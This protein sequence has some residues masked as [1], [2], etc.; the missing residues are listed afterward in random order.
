MNLS[1]L[2]TTLATTIPSVVIFIELFI[3]LPVLDSVY[4]IR[5]NA[6]KALRLFSSRRISEHWKEKAVLRYARLIL[7]ASLQN[8]ICLIILVLSFSL[9]FCLAGY[10]L[11]DN[12]K[13]VLAQ[14]F[15]LKTQIVAIG[16]GVIYAFFRKK[17]K[18]RKSVNDYSMLSK[19]LHHLALDSSVIKKV[20]FDVDCQVSRFRQGSGKSIKP[21]FVT[22]LARAGTTIL[23]EALYSTGLFATLT[24]RDMPFV[25]APL[26]WK[27]LTS[28]N[29]KESDLKERAHGDRLK[30]N[31]DSPEAFE[32]VFWMT[33]TNGDYIKES[34]LEQHDIDEEVTENYRKFVNNVIAG[35][36]KQFQ[37]L[38][39]AKNN[40]N[41]LRISA[42]KEA[43]PDG[44]IVV[45][46]RN[47]LDHAKSLHNQHKRFSQIHSE[48]AFSLRYMNWLGHYEF[49]ENFKP[50]KFSDEVIPKYEGEPEELDYWLRY[51][52]C[53][54]EYVIDCHISD[55]ILFDYDM[56][57]VDPENGL[58][59]L[60]RTL[61][62]D[63]ALM[64]RFQ[65]KV[66]GA[67][68]YEHIDVER[69]IL[70][71]AEKVHARLLELSL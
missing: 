12:L 19:T 2:F 63:E 5:D 6:F 25:T 58:K 30:V 40:N 68:K 28:G 44:A 45:P 39:L 1:E 71:D 51:W 21:V 64:T 54:H 9:V 43:F 20:A 33:F 31:Y 56:F 60:A 48:D 59:K 13:E 70:G 15:S 24:Y 49:G 29:R 27:L 8:I 65:A 26:F 3:Y 16:V 18:Q 11:Y 32:E 66:K 4:T 38:Y 17:M 47:P 10:L 50:L 62:L 61:S 42:L 14:L 46:F 69:E 52:K 55:V 22:G 34:W 41:L 57:C 23:L 37:A 67:T 35:S 53:I 36:G 7:G